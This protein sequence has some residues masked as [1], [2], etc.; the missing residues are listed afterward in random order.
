MPFPPQ[1]QQPLPGN[2]KR[3]FRLGKVKADRIGQWRP[4]PTDQTHIAR[5][6][7]QDAE[8]PVNEAARFLSARNVFLLEENGLDT[9]CRFLCLRQSAQLIFNPLLP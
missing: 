8:L 4:T 6:Y 3:S 9:H 2:V 7:K 1:A 5:F